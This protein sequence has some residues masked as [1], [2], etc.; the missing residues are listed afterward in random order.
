M[1]HLTV[2][3][4]HVTDAFQKESSLYNCVNIKEIL[5]WNRRNIWS[6]SYYNRTRTHNSLVRK[7]TLNHLVKHPTIWPN[8]PN[9]WVVLWVLICTVH[10]TVCCYHLT[11]AFQSESSLYI[12]LN[13]Q[14]QLNHLARFVKW[15][16][17]GWRTKWLWVRVPL[18]WLR[19][20]V[21]RLFWTR[22]SL[23][24]WE[25]QNED[26]LSDVYVTW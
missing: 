9:D 23:T 10:L 2:R 24:F 15:L 4:Y 8:W 11:Y 14:V 5:D 20:Q 19:L 16:S 22:S 12:C 26:S 17:V 6:L 18:M 13:A 21:L 1:V 25:I 7:Q 3:C